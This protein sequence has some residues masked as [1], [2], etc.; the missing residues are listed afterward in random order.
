MTAERPGRAALEADLRRVILSA[1]PELTDLASRAPLISSG[2][3]ESTA[4]L[5]VAL[6]VEDQVGAP[7]EL[8]EVDLTEEWDTLEG[9]VSFVE[10]RGVPSPGAGPPR[11]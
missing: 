1:S 7:V 3:L 8:G 9:I 6:W 2:L 5:S 11:P 4:L 10:R